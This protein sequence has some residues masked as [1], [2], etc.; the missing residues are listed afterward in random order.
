MKFAGSRFFENLLVSLKPHKNSGYFT[1]RPICIYDISLN[2]SWNEKLSG[3]KLKRKSKR[4]LYCQYIFF[5][6]IVPF[7]R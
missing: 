7:V 4:T 1:C 5:S 2:S 3:Q 6:K